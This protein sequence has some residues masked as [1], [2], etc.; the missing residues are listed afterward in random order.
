MSGTA[1]VVLGWG[2]FPWCGDILVH[3]AGAQQVQ[4]GRALMNLTL[5]GDPCLK[6]QSAG[7]AAGAVASPVRWVSR[8]SPGI[9]A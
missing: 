1:A 8:I 7:I 5:I 2:L 6:I 9:A 4:T 3:P